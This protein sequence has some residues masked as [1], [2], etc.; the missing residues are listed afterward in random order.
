MARGDFPSAK[1]DQFVLRF[2]DRMRGELKDEAKKNSR[3]LNAE[4]ISRL[5]RTLV[6]DAGGDQNE[7]NVTRF[8]P[9]SEPIV[10][11]LREI[12]QL[13]AEMAKAGKGK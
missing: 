4:I 9:I 2:P 8:E 1:Q 12:R 11:L 3:S 10:E 13:R 7:H 5:Q 6:S